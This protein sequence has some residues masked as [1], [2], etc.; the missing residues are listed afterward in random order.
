MRQRHRTSVSSRARKASGSSIASSGARTPGAESRPSWSSSAA[1]AAGSEVE[2][3]L[4]PRVTV[5][6][7]TRPAVGRDVD[8]VNRHGLGRLRVRLGLLAGLEGEELVEEPGR[9]AEPEARRREAT[10]RH[11]AAWRSPSGWCRCPWSRPTGSGNSRSAS[12]GE[13]LDRL[14]L[15]V[16]HDHRLH[17]E[18]VE[19]RPHRVGRGKGMVGRGR[20][21]GRGPDLHRLGRLR[22][23]ARAA[24]RASRFVLP[25]A[26]PSPRIAVRAGLAEALVEA[27]CSRVTWKSPPRST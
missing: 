13:R 2:R 25:G 20:V 5:M 24:A 3:A 21:A 27:S 18:L 4:P 7:S 15:A 19:E 14:H 22:R 10:E 17:A 1:R 6:P 11:A 8:D 9:E 12:P 26:E 23:G 16:D